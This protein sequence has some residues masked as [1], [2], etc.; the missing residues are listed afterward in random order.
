MGTIKP[1]EALV[2]ADDATTQ[3]ALHARLPAGVGRDVRGEPMA[4]W[5]A[6]ALTVAAV[7]GAV[8]AGS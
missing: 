4:E 8:I 6:I 7:L 3:T 5:L 1:K 2:A